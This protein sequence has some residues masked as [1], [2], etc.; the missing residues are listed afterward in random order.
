MPP[1]VLITVVA[2][3]LSM[4]ASI[5]LACF[6]GFAVLVFG[7]AATLQIGFSADFPDEQITAVGPLLAAAAT[8]VSSLV[9]AVL[10]GIGAYL[11]SKHSGRATVLTAAGLAMGASAAALYWFIAGLGPERD[12]VGLAFGIVVPALLPLAALVGA[13]LP[14]TRAWCATRPAPPV[15]PGLPAASPWGPYR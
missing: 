1:R 9:A 6:A 4:V 13:M 2:S 10:F 11:L 3:W 7:F 8:A 15:G 12:W 14:Q 5:W